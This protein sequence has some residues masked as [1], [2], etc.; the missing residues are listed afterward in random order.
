MNEGSATPV[1]GTDARPAVTLVTN[2]VVT[3]KTGHHC[4]MHVSTNYIKIGLLAQFKKNK[5]E[6]E[7]LWE[8]STSCSSCALGIPL[9]ADSS[10]ETASGPSPGHTERDAP[11]AKGVT[12]LS[13]W[14]SSVQYSCEAP[15]II[16]RC[17]VLFGF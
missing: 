8:F 9:P 1:L 12:A 15:V 2:R 17:H 6:L 7:T 13:S 14:P 3:S 4:G 11:T 5:G 16:S 10:G